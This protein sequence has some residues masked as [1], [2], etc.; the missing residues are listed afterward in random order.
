MVR[1]GV[2]QVSLRE[3]FCDEKLCYPVVGSVIVFR[4]YSHLSA[5]YSRA[6]VPYISK[7]L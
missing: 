2:K 6:L 3:Q 1:E 4:D 7:Q 5:E